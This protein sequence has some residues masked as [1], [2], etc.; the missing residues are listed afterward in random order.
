MRNGSGIEPARAPQ[1]GRVFSSCPNASLEQPPPVC[2]IVVAYRADR[3]AILIRGRSASPIKS[4][5]IGQ[6]CAQTGVGCG[7]NVNE[8]CGRRKRRVT[9]GL[10]HPARWIGMYAYSHSVS[11]N[12]LKT[13]N[14]PT[15]PI[16][17]LASRATPPLIQKRAKGSHSPWT[18]RLHLN[19]VSAPACPTLLVGR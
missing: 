14:S 15:T 1:R 2:A 16:D 4:G 7:R 3:P 11:S 6:R 17:D 8:S 18:Q 5:G 10:I 9:G 13:R 19:G 12:V